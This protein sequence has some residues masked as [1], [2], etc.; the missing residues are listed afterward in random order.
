[1]SKETWMIQSKRQGDTT[2]F[3][4]VFD[5]KENRLIVDIIELLEKA[6]TQLKDKLEVEHGSHTLGEKVND[7]E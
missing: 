3:V 4:K 2:Y 1:M 6:I 7:N 5:T